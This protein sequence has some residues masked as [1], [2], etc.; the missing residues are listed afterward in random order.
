M[1]N[2]SL[3][4]DQAGEITQIWNAQLLT[5]SGDGY[6]VENIGW[7][8]K[9]EV[10]ASIEFGYVLKSGEIVLPTEARY[11]GEY[12]I[13]TET[14]PIQGASFRVQGEGFNVDFVVENAWENHCNMNV[15]LTNTGTKVMEN[16]SLSYTQKGEIIQIWNAQIAEHDGNKYVIE[17]QNQTQKIANGESISFG[18][19]VQGS[20]L[21]IPAERR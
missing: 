13:L 4:F 11:T 15:I 7:N 20:V 10:G 5:Q 3:F 21:E 8:E 2:W 16:W 18:Y 9:I 1:K 12:F 6:T 19:T 14:T 17:G